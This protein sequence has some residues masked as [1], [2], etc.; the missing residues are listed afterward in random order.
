[1][2][3]PKTTSDRHETPRRS[4]GPIIGGSLSRGVEAR[5]E[6]TSTPEAL[7]SGQMVVVE[8]E[9]YDFFGMITDLALRSTSPEALEGAPSIDLRDE[10]LGA[11]LRGNTY[12]GLATLRLSL[13]R[14]RGARVDDEEALEPARTIP[15]HFAPARIAGSA[16]V[17]RVFGRPGEGGYYRIGS[18]IEMKDVSVCVD[19]D[20][21]VERSSGIFGKSGT[22]KTFL[23]RLVL[24]GIIRRA[25]LAKQTSSG[26]RPPTL[27][28]FD[29]HNEYAHGSRRE[30]GSVVKG[31]ADYFPA[32][33]EV[34]SLG[35]QG[36]RGGRF[37]VQIPYSQIEPEDVLLLSDELNL[38][39]TAAEC[40][41][42]AQARWGKAWFQRMID[43]SPEAAEERKSLG[44]HEQAIRAFWQRLRYLHS[45]C[46]SF[47]CDRL[48]P[49][50]D[51]V[52]Q[53]MINLREGK[54][55]IVEFGKSRHLLQY[56]FVA[57][58]LTRRIH[59]QYTEATEAYLAEPKPGNEPRP[60]VIVLEEAHKFLSPTL[61][62]QTIFGTIAREM[63]KYYVTLL[64]VDQRPSQIDPEIHSQLG[65]KLICHLDNERDVEAVLAGASAE[66]GLR[67]VLANLRSKQQALILG[68]A[69]RMPVVVDTR[70][71]GDKEFDREIGFR[72]EEERRRDADLAAQQLGGL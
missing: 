69:V 13:M 36:S 19:L 56:M 42:L 33:V 24:A 45:Q 60:A 31:L 17:E 12:Y 58:I 2:S 23:T 51:A 1:M 68:H 25:R 10:P 61:A 67:G 27:L 62:R 65:T 22:G 26:T 21:L 35:S 54:H 71:Y 40:A 4:I 46:Q 50:L 5:L 44:A 34:F 11:I 32:D 41:Y 38:T 55:T 47:L 64:I 18:P 9:R 39:D 43:P 48:S 20:R 63:R 70:T 14:A 49:E 72:T 6:G 15:G 29:M 66:M 28:V 52:R 57:N 3:E 53:I 59:A 30:E 8:G 7:R 37:V 16:D